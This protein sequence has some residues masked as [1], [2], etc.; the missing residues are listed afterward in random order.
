VKHENATFGGR[1]LASALTRLAVAF[2]YLIYFTTRWRVVGDRY[3]RHF[4]ETGTPCIAAFWHG[5]LA[6]LPSGLRR[7]LRA[8]RYRGRFPVHMLISD[9]GD[10]L[11]ISAVIRHFAIDTIAG[12]TN[13]GASSA[14]RAMIRCLRAGEY[15]AITP[16]GPNGPAMRASPGAVIAASMTGAPI[17]P[18][19]YATSRRRILDSWDRFHLPLP[20]GR[21]VIVW[22]EPIE[23]PRDLDRDGIERWRRHLED[24]LISLTVEADQMVG[25][26]VVA[27]GT[28]SRDEWRAERYAARQA[29]RE[30]M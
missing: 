4:V 17:L 30:P 8:A 9:H 10:G 15:V 7:M 20:F 18:Y 27:P 11:F 19:T 3:A 16:D 22:G 26:S 23:V 5:R 1:L 28:M 25:Q 13:R 24:R 12:S 14:M 6:M 2:V 29:A 21:G